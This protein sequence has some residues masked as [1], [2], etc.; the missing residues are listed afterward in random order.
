MVAQIA[1]GVLGQLGRSR[2]PR[3]LTPRQQGLDDPLPSPP[4]IGWSLSEKASS[5]SR[6]PPHHR[7]DRSDPVALLRTLA[8][9][10]DNPGTAPGPLAPLLDNVSAARR[11]V[12]AVGLPFSSPG[13][14]LGAR[15]ASAPA[16]RH[17]PSVDGGGALLG[18]AARG[19]PCTAR[20]WSSGLSAHLWLGRVL[21]WLGVP[22][23]S[24]RRRGRPGLESASTWPA[25]ST[26][27]TARP[28]HGRR[29]HG[30]FAACCR[31]GVVRRT[32]VPGGPDTYTTADWA[33]V[34]VQFLFWVWARAV[35][36]YRR[37]GVSS[38][39]RCWGY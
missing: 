11:Y 22:L 4:R 17:D 25:P 8:G 10:W 31:H 2:R 23:W 3:R 32:S 20:S 9:V 28:G 33:A 39:P 12:H 27:R 13:G 18:L 5:S 30:G 34:S 16:P 1:G 35:V 15:R 21:L 38:S 7:L 36:R 29:E 6:T 24:H 19:A 37:K 14:A 26:Q